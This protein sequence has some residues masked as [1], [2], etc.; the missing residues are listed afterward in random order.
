[1]AML[2]AS[3]GHPVPFV[4]D[5]NDRYAAEKVAKIQSRPCRKC[6]QIQQV[7][8]ET[9]VKLAS[10]KRIKKG[11]EPKALPPGTV[12]RLIREQDGSWTG[13]LW[14]EGTEVSANSNGTMGIISKLARRWLDT[15]GKSLTGVVK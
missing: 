9:A 8:H 7:A 1:M 6:R 10:S 12:V 15:K 14:A 2:T 4:E 13:K 11:Q 3:C 5:H